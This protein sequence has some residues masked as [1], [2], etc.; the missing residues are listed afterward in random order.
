MALKTVAFGMFCGDLTRDRPDFRLRAIRRH[1]RRQSANHRHR[2]APAIRLGTQRE[3][4]IQIEVTARREHR[5][6]IEGFRQHADHRVRF[7][8][9]RQR[10]ADDRRVGVE[11]PLPQTVAQHHGLRTV[12]RAFLRVEDAT[13]LWPDAEHVEEVLGN[14]DAAEA[15]RF[16]SAAQQVVADAVKREVPCDRRQRLRTLP[17]VQHVPHLR[18][19]TGEPTRVAVRDPDELFRMAEWQRPQD[20]RVDDAEDGGAGADAKRGDEDGKGGKARIASQR[21]NGVAQV[22]EEIVEGHITTLDGGFADFV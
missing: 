16:A 2:V 6:E 8:V 19:L 17:Q 11:A 4:E 15:F 1:A 9:Q 7:A 20:Q 10:R 14:R 18:R 22:L 12:P 3:R 5:G 13:Q 21:A